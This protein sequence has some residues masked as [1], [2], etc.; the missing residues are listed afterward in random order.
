MGVSCP[1][2]ASRSVGGLALLP[3]RGDSLSDP[4]AGTR[5]PARVRHH[6]TQPAEARPAE[7]RP[8]RRSPIGE[9]EVLF[10]FS[11]GRS[12]R[13]P[14]ST[15]SGTRTRTPP[16]RTRDFKSL[17]SADFAIPAFDSPVFRAPPAA[18]SPTVPRGTAAPVRTIGRNRRAR[19]REFRRRDARRAAG[20]DN[21]PSEGV[22]GRP[23]A[24]E[25]ARAPSAAV[26]SAHPPTAA[27]I[28][29]R[30]EPNERL[31]RITGGRAG[32]GGGRIRTAE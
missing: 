30:D 27:R 1:A 6:R 10:G 12:S 23:R 13:G 19:T 16:W 7:E 31:R 18:P 29:E 32:G 11:A 2:R 22:R 14:P 8:A 3:V 4:S 21:K 24:S 9:F 5:W 15:G 17:A 25:G 28:G 20:P 26:P